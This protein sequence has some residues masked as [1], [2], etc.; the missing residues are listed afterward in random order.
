MKKYSDEWKVYLINML[1]LCAKTI[2]DNA[3]EIIGDYEFTDNLDITITM[4]TASAREGFPTITVSKDYFPDY[5]IA[6]KHLDNFQ[7]IRKK[8]DEAR[9]KTLNDHLMVKK[10]GDEE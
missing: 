4:S 8:K 10:E 6:A 2:E 7:K 1:I 3:E 5:D 9:S